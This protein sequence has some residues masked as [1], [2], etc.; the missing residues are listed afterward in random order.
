[1]TGTPIRQPALILA[2]GLGTRLTSVL[3]DRPKV[4]APIQEDTFLDHL[5]A[6]LY[7]GGLRRLVLLLGYRHEMVEAHLDQVLRK[8]YPDLEFVC[9]VEPSPLGTA[10]ALRLAGKFCDDT[11][12]LING[13]TYV[14]FDAR[15]LLAAHLQN[16]AL[17]TLAARRVEDASRYGSLDCDAQGRILGFRE[18]SVTTG[19]GL[20]NAGVYVMEP[21]VLDLI[22]A[23]GPVSLEQDVLPSLIKAGERLWTVEL[24][25]QFFDIG[26]PASYAEFSVFLQRLKL[27]NPM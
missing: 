2:G 1:M 27:D 25:G 24:G 20:I 7:A 3:P 21:R 16:H 14:E 12:L 23:T 19:G 10:G 26:T 22:A 13:D 4:L 17:V 18:K 11:F 8:R 15:H 5:V 9:S 6:Q